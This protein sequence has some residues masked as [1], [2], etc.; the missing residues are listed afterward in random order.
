MGATTSLRQYE[1]MLEINKESSFSFAF[2]QVGDFTELYGLKCALGAAMCSITSIRTLDECS[3][4]YVCL[5][6][7]AWCAGARV[8]R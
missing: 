4:L 8:A 2:V 7:G 3:V 6:K 1:S 5:G